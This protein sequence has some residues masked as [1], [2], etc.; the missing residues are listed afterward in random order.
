MTH[1]DGQMLSMI[2]SSKSFSTEF[3][4]FYH[5]VL[6]M[7]CCVVFLSFCVYFHR[8]F[9]IIK[10]FLTFFSF[11]FF[12][13]PPV[14]TDHPPIVISI[15]NTSLTIL[16]YT[17]LCTILYCVPYYTWS[18]Y[19]IVYYTILCYTSLYFSQGLKTKTIYNQ[20]MW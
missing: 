7:L 1:L 20:L 8:F 19:T 15:P 11:F 6:I 4:R 17:L 5:V 2:W 14:C 18:N 16:Y 12:Q 13:L 3:T 9:P 10:I